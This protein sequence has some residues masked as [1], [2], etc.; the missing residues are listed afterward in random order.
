[1]SARWRSLK[2]SARLAMRS[3]LVSLYCVL[4]SILLNTILE[5]LR[6]WRRY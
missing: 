5:S 3:P 4:I 1:M 2:E 6:L